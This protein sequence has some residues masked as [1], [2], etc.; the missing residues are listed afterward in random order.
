MSRILIIE[1]ERVVAR[2]LQAFL[3]T[4]GYQTSLAAS[5]EE[6][7]G[8]AKSEQPDVALVDIHLAGTLDGIETAQALRQQTEVGVV[9]LTAYGDDQTLERAESTEPLGY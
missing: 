4:C 6:A 2:D 1:D 8:V 5:G 9:Y 3:T 7:I